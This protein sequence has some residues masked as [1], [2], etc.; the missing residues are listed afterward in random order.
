[1]TSTIKS[2]LV[3]SMLSMANYS[4]AE[5]ALNWSVS[6]SSGMPPPPVLRHEPLP[7]QQ[8]GQIWVRGYWDWN[9]SAYLWVPG[10]W[11]RERTGYVYVQPAWREGA[12]G[13]DLRRGGWHREDSDVGYRPRAGGGHCPPGQRK[14]GEC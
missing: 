12:R 10:H 7:L 11:V 3:L 14:K 6:V 2:M 1:M 8:A 4:T 5:S 9:G 13:W